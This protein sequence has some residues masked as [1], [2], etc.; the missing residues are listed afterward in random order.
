M[1]NDNAD[2]AVQLNALAK[3]LAAASG[4][5]F[6]EVAQNLIAQGAQQVDVFARAYSPVKTGF[7]RDAITTNVNGL[8]AT[9]STNAPYSRYLEYG[10]GTRSEFPGQP[11]TINA[12]PGGV[13]AFKVN[14]RMVYAK[15]VVS[16]GMAPRPFM[17]P[18]VERVAWPFAENLANSAV[19]TIVH[20]PNSPQNIQPS[21]Q[22][23]SKGETEAQALIQTGV[24]AGKGV[25]AAKKALA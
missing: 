3:D 2:A 1:R 11:I 19:T 20:G 6:K 22:S 12:R 18:A 15:K 7:N 21:S 9:I 10:T 17:R 24:R 13:L 23:T 4:Q 14:G 25:S 8:E 5:P 16:P